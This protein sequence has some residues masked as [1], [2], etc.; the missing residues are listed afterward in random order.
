MSKGVDVNTL[1]GI[2]INWINRIARQI[3]EG[4]LKFNPARIVRIPKAGNLT[5]S[6]P[7]TIAS[8]REKVVPKAIQFVLGGGAC[9]TG[10]FVSPTSHPPK[11]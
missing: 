11:K 8:P 6:R 1:E 10:Y 4:Y 3:Q 9:N 2:A 5:E 7:L